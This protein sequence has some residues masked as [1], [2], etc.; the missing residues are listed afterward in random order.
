M[1]LLSNSILRVN[2][3]KAFEDQV[4]IH[5]GLADDVMWIFLINTYVSS[6]LNLFNIGYGIKLLKRRKIRNNL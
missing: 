3:G 2:E 4:E 5:G 6:F 1:V